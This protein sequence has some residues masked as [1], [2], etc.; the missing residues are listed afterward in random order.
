MTVS[1]T[2]AAK[3]V[4]TINLDGTDTDVWNTKTIKDL[5][6][7][8][9][10]TG[11]SNANIFVKYTANGTTDATAPASNT[12]A[13]PVEEG[14]ALELDQYLQLTAAPSATKGTI[15]GPTT[16]AVA[17][18]DTSGVFTID[19]KN[20]LKAGTA[21]SFKVTVTST[22]AAGA[23]EKV[24]NG[25]KVT[26]AS[27]AATQATLAITSPTGGV[28]AAADTVLDSTHSIEDTITCSVAIPDGLNANTALTITVLDAA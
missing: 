14:D 21:F 11:K 16:S 7:E 8:K 10:G 6:E 12:D 2:I 25:L 5:Y 26:V 24:D 4:V 19:S 27:G 20:F 1:Q 17:L 13:N 15:T 3:K 22:T 23:T 28:I 9:F 18:S